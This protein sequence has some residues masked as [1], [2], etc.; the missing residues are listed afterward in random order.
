MNPFAIP[1]L[2]S[3]LVAL[4]LGG[5]VYSKN[6]HGRT[7]RIFLVFCLLAAYAGFTEFM[8]RNAGT[9]EEAVIWRRSG[10]FWPFVIAVIVHFVLVSTEHESWIKRKAVL[11]ALYAPAFCFSLINILDIREGAIPIRR[12]WGWTYGITNRYLLIWSFLMLTFTADIALRFF[13]R[14][15][16]RRKKKQALFILISF[17]IPVVIAY[18]T[19]VIYITGGRIPELFTVSFILGS[20]FIA[21][22]IWKYGLFVLTPKTTGETI[23]DAMTDGLFLI[24]PDGTIVSVN[25]AG[26]ALLKM[27][28]ESILGS[29]LFSYLADGSEKSAFFELWKLTLHTHTPIQDHEMTLQ[30]PGGILAASVSMSAIVKAGQ[31]EGIVF[32][33]RDI[34]ERA[35]ARI[36]LMKARDS[37]EAANRAKSVFLANMS[38][39]IRTPMNS[40]LGFT[41]ILL[42]MEESKEKREMLEIINRS[43]KNLLNLINDILDFSK[44][45][46]GKVEL[47][48]ITFSLGHLLEDI[49]SLFLVRANEKNLSFQLNIDEAL[50]EYLFGDEHRI[51]QII[52]NLVSN[53][54]KFT[55]K[56][57]IA[58]SCT[59]ESGIAVIRVK[60]TGIG[61]PKQ[62]QKSV[63]S[64]F[65]QG[66]VSTT[67]EFGGTGLGLAITQKL[68]EKMGG[69]IA[70]KSEPEKGTEFIVRLSLPEVKEPE[71]LRNAETHS[72]Y[73]YDPARTKIAL[74]DNDE[75]D[76][77]IIRNLLMK[78]GFSPIIIPNTPEAARLVY[79][80]EAEIVLLD[81]KMDGLNGF[82]VNDILK[83][84][85]RT[86]H[87]PVIVC[88]I[89]DGLE[90]TINYGVFDYIRKPVEERTF[91]KRIKSALYI[92]GDVKNIFVIDDDKD[93]LSLYKSMLHAQKYNVF[94][95]DNAQGALE[96]IK[97]GIVPDLIL[98]DL[99]MPG[100]D[101]FEFLGHLRDKL[102]REEIPVIIVTAK[103]LTG[104]D[105][106][107]LNEKCLNIYKKAPDTGKSLVDF[108]NSYFKRKEHRGS[109]MVNAWVQNFDRD[110]A[111]Q[112]LLQDGIKSLP[113]KIHEVNSAYEKGSGSEAFRR[114]I[115]DMKGFTGNYGMKE[116][117]QAFKEIDAVLKEKEPAKEKIETCL[118]RINTLAESLPRERDS[119]SEEK[120]LSLLVAE[121]NPMNQELIKTLLSRS[122]YSHTVVSNGEEVLAA[123]KRE[124]YDILLLDIQMPVMDG[125]ETIQ[126]IRRNPAFRDLWV[127]ALTAYAVKGDEERFLEAG[128]DDYI[129]KPIVQEAFFQKIK[130]GARQKGF[131]LSLSDESKEK[132]FF[133][134]YLT[135][136]EKRKMKSVLERLETE[137]NAFYPEKIQELADELV[138][139]KESPQTAALAQ[140]L[141]DLAEEYNDEEIRRIVN[142]HK[143]RLHDQ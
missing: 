22:G 140:K 66:D 10:A 35:K 19:N 14:V 61:I 122:G 136:E 121:D 105:L 69:E 46:A 99:M 118:N 2:L 51:N 63:F 23:V 96:D 71:K 49:R 101:G 56:G 7:N 127:I 98:L 17:A 90:E 24:L 125:M 30:V 103:D 113:G 131:L 21:Y 59:Y 100:I 143:E 43:G 129:S 55:K 79:E 95:F 58:L 135:E 50:P 126:H 139:I 89:M 32:I 44:I 87:I 25:K 97:K 1:S 48:K 91:M 39:E 74:I 120:K 31:I 15:T 53:A 108:I 68:V 75:N 142:R 8:L 83:S 42:E 72:L 110:E 133:E 36:D 84:D 80:S 52:I 67:R 4:F 3:S 73:H 40:I 65:K 111:L 13:L 93:L 64:A 11:F 60:D 26:S 45:E 104:D 85:A 38:H 119:F 16:D 47:E 81:L 37:A 6:S 12:Y 54:V 92:N 130:Y 70:L 114:I 102:K 137:I 134:N 132:D 5:F 77:A 117:Y 128:C 94:L 78:R 27:K 57:G 109:A 41:G 20:G 115:H 18:I 124:N 29:S 34:S 76:I 138:S 116:F 123:L 86:S 107:R 28:E 106:Q 88:S 9:P 141:K 62:K 82:Q 33:L 112:K